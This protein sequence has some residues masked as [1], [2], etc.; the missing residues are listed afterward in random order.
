MNIRNGSPLRPSDNRALVN[1]FNSH[2]LKHILAAQTSLLPA[3]DTQRHLDPPE[4]SLLR[5]LLADALLCVAGKIPKTPGGCSN[6]SLQAA[7]D[8]SWFSDP[9]MT[10]YSFRWICE[11]LRLD[12]DCILRFVHSAY[13]PR[14]EIS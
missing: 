5:A 12:P 13:S 3:Q 14:K 1:P 9:S 10:P 7:R 11:Y 2:T 8:F 6:P 4:I